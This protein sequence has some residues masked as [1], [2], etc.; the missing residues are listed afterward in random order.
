MT[1]PGDNGYPPTRHLP[2]LQWP[3]PCNRQQSAGSETYRTK[4]AMLWRAKFMTGEVIHVAG[5][6]DQWSMSSVPPVRKLSRSGFYW[7]YLHPATSGRRHHNSTAYGNISTTSWFS[8]FRRSPRSSATI[9]TPTYQKLLYVIFYTSSPLL[10]SA[11]YS[12]NDAECNG[13]ARFSRAR[14]SYV[15]HKLVILSVDP[16]RD[17]PVPKPSMC[18]W[19]M[20]DPRLVTEPEHDMRDI[21][22]LHPCVPFAPTVRHNLIPFMG[23]DHPT[24]ICSTVR[25]LS[26]YI[27][28][29]PHNTVKLLAP[30]E[31]S[32][33]PRIW[34]KDYIVKPTSRSTLGTTKPQLRG[35]PYLLLEPTRLAIV[36]VRDQTSWDEAMVALCFC[37]PYHTATA[38][39]TVVLE[40]FSDVTGAR[41]KTGHTREE[42]RHPFA[43][44]FTGRKTDIEAV[45]IDGSRRPVILSLALRAHARGVV[46]P[47][48]STC[49]VNF[50]AVTTE[51]VIFL[52]GLVVLTVAVSCSDSLFTVASLDSLVVPST[53]CDS[54]DE[55]L[56][57]S[58]YKNVAWTECEHSYCGGPLQPE[59][60]VLMDAGPSLVDFLVHV[61]PR[62]TYE[63]YIYLS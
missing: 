18:I 49:N 46:L 39:S 48:E 52:D 42:D 3:D 21:R 50:R 17:L 47:V 62:G 51:E 27:A 36:R 44:G 41:L 2:W 1:L 12:R 6:G 32:G 22:S 33:N 15:P 59:L 55:L 20:P 5:A 10:N 13:M 31:D 35:I 29:K 11:T 45:P 58:M 56:G 7:R 43:L 8:C 25:S 54:R 34:R 4:T 63:F 60:Q 9:N 37:S 40:L 26:A 38:T 24:E 23:I 53:Y 19:V 61:C 16:P 30:D 14:D 57:H 28:T